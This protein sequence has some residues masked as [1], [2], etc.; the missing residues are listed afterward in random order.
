M[1]TFKLALLIITVFLSNFTQAQDA[2]II[3]PSGFDQVK[4]EVSKGEVKEISY[5][6]KTVGVDRVANIYFPPGYTA[7]EAYPVLYLLHGIGGDE[8]E[9]LDQGTPNVILDNLYA[10][11]KAKPMIIVMPNGRAMENDRAEGDIFGEEPVKAFA[12][13]EKDLM[14]DLIPFIEKSYKVKPGIENRAVAG[15]SMGGGQS[16]NFG[17]NHP[18]DFAWVGGFSPAPNTKRGSDLL[19]QADV[20]RENLKLLFLSCG[21][22]DNLMRVAN[23]THDYLNEQNI[24]HTYRVIPGHHHNFEYWKNELY[25]FVQEIF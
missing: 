9:W 12:R 22:Q 4:E 17:L 24:D 19:P 6:S 3:A 15:L 11:K 2:E 18:E 7:S 20:S 23:Q 21:D 10:D 13:F 14:D 8:R 16:L 25:F 5:P 1:K